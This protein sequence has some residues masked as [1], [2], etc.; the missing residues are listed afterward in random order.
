[1]FA[2]SLVEYGALGALV[3]GL[4]H[5]ADTAL[6]WLGTLPPAAWIAVAAVVA[7]WMFARR[8]R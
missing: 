4:Q 5:S 6:T 1:M 7:L 2:Q 3:A 8:G